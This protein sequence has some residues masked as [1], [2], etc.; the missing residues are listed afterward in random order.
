[1]MEWIDLGPA[2]PEGRTTEFSS[3]VPASQWSAGSPESIWPALMMCDL[4]PLIGNKSG[5]Y[6]CARVG[7]DNRICEVVYWYH[8]GGDWIPWGSCLPEALVFDAL[9]SRLP[10][11]HHRHAEPAEMDSSSDFDASDPLIQWAC[12]H[13]PEEIQTI[14]QRPNDFSGQEVANAMLRHD[15]SAVAV[16]LELTEAA[17]FPGASEP[18]RDA[19]EALAMEV[20]R[21]RCPR[22]EPMAWVWNVAGDAA[23][24]N[25]DVLTAMNRFGSGLMASN[26]SDQSVRLKHSWDLSASGK[27]AADR[28]NQ[29]VSDL[30]EHDSEMH[31]KVDSGLKTEQAELLNLYTGDVGSRSQRVTD[32]WTRRAVNLERAGDFASAHDCMVRAGWDL[33]AAPLEAYESLIGEVARLAE[34][35]G[36]T[37][38]AAVARTHLACFQDRYGK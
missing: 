30:Q 27:Y 1:M 16:Q 3:P 18:N 20:V 4:L 11:P 8:G 29:L 33:G 32:Y 9:R 6:L 13:L 22:L 21:H 31:A 26:F 36:Q 5:D 14:V 17:L 25:G 10:G 15:V 23:L 2:M 24:K 7:A 28:L 37:A 35:A 38:R 34:L 19:A 12:Q